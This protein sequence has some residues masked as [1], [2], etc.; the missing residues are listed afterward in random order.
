M[1]DNEGNKYY[2]DQ[3]N[4]TLMQQTCKDVFRITADDKNNVDQTHSQHI[5]RY[6]T[7]NE[8]KVKSFP[9]ANL[10]RINNESIYMREITLEELKT[11]IRS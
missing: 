1:K 5:D 10:N 8:N 3:E 6:I 11:Y 2:S 9:T 4:C 7:A